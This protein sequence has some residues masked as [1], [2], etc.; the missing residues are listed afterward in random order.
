[1]VLRSGILVLCF[2]GNVY[3]VAEDGK[4]H[5]PIRAN[6]MPIRAHANKAEDKQSASEDHTQACGA[7]LNANTRTPGQGVLQLTD[8]GVV[9]HGVHDVCHEMMSSATHAGAPL[10]FCLHTHCYC[11][12]TSALVLR[13]VMALVEHYKALLGAK[14]P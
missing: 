9:A 6:I 5:V 7:C 10:P 3:D 13:L 14:E 2:V 8:L 1:M 12:K 11:T 4:Q